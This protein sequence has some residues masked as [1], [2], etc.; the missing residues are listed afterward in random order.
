MVT[1]NRGNC[2][3]FRQFRGCC[4]RVLALRDCAQKPCLKI[5][6]KRYGRMYSA[7]LTQSNQNHPVDIE[8]DDYVVLL[9]FVYSMLVTMKELVYNNLF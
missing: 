1:V 2:L 7:S 5:C 4:L 9:V 6:Y 8:N 3:S